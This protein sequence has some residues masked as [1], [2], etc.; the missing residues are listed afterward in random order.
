MDLLKYFALDEAIDVF[1]GLVNAGWMDLCLICDS[2]VI[3]G[4]C[5][6]AV[7]LIWFASHR[8][9]FVFL[10][11]TLFTLFFFSLLF[12]LPHI[13]PSFISPLLPPFPSFSPLF[14][15]DPS[16]QP[17]SQSPKP[18]LPLSQSYDDAFSAAPSSK[19]VHTVTP[20]YQFR[21]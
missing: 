8:A 13:P 4:G 19:P 14:L 7:V 1:A 6:Y 5:L 18:S 9:A 16:L 12:P 15:F 10:Y 20:C 11:S 17:I 2:E 21:R 3:L